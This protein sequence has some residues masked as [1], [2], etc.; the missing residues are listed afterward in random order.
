MNSDLYAIVLMISE[1][2]HGLPVFTGEW[3]L[4]I[5]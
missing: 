5:A 2:S 4:D 1:S 3:P